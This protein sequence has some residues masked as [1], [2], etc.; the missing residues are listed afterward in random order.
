[1]VGVEKR[2]LSILVDEA[3]NAEEGIGVLGTK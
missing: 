1:M 3:I 2:G